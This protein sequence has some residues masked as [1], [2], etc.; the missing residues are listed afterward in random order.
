MGVATIA[1]TWMALTSALVRLA[2]NLIQGERSVL[3]RFLTIIL[4]SPNINNLAPGLSRALAITSI[5][6]IAHNRISVPMGSS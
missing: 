1:L 4:K 5:F 2:M 3:V 6:R